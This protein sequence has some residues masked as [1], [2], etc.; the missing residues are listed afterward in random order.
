MKAIKKL[1]NDGT[2]W[3][4]KHDFAWRIIYKQCVA[5]MSVRIYRKE[6]VKIFMKIW[7]IPNILWSCPQ[8]P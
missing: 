7:L 6:N 8:R 5:N 3:L 1:Q 2:I 4:V